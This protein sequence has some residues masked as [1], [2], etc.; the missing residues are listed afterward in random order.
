MRVRR[1]RRPHAPAPI[2]ELVLNANV[3]K[4]LRRHVKGMERSVRVFAM[5]KR[6][7]E[8]LF[9]YYR[10]KAGI[11]HGCKLY[12]LRHTA[13]MRMVRHT[14]DLRLVQAIMGHQRLRAT[15]VYLQSDPNTLRRAFAAT[16]TVL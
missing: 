7:S 3:A 5:T 16:G 2:T 8:R 10:N 15:S 13:G 1:K 12:G 9:H 14:R 4:L 6:Q 11:T